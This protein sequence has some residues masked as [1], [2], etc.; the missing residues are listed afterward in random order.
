MIIDYKDKY[1]KLKEKLYKSKKLTKKERRQ[2]NKL[3]EWNY[4]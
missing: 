3:V 4:K 2:L 1:I